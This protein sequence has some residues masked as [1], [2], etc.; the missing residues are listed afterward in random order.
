[1]LGRIPV[2][3]RIRI[4]LIVLMPAV[5]SCA[6]AQ[7]V[8][9]MPVAVPRAT[10]YRTTI[11]VSG[12]IAA[13]K[14]ATLAAQRA[15]VVRAVLFHSGEHVVKDAVLLRMDDA[16]EQAQVA[17]DRAKRDEAGRTLAR[18][19]KLRAIAGVSEAQLETDRAALAEARAQLALDTARA[20]RRTIRAPFA[21]VLGIRRVSSGDYVALGAT[22]TTIT[23]IRPLRVLF[24]VPETEL[25]GIA[26][27]DGFRF[28]MPVGGGLDH[29]GRITAL[30]PALNGKTRARMVE[31]RIANTSDALLPGAFGVV[32]IATGTPVAA[33]RLPA[34][35]IDYGPL[36]SFVYAVD[37]KG[38]AS[39]VHA[40]YVHVLST[41]GAVATVAA[42]GLPAL[43]AVV[44]IGGFK[45]HDGETITPI[46]PAAPVQASR[47]A[48][49]GRAAEPGGQS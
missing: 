10:Q 21:G 13:M 24:A 26:P 14:S 47:A 1:M 37:R 42:K 31:G 45:L 4:L 7:A 43:G 28:A 5:V 23:Q 29:D 19:R 16:V 12:Q 39:V 27:G 20:D 3:S 32:S 35:S 9:C 48:K 46:G 15:G 36:G 33:L 25:D 49:P 30:S 18:D 6:Y 2:R 11:E 17:L 41:Q 22:I 38:K 44:A 8:P 40:V 34:T